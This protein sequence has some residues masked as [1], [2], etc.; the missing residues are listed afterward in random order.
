MAQAEPSENDF[1]PF[2]PGGVM[3]GAGFMLLRTRDEFLREL[4]NCDEFQA[5]CKERGTLPE[6]PFG[7][8]R[9]ID[10]AGRIWTDWSATEYPWSEL[11]REREVHQLA[12]RF[13]EVSRQT[14]LKVAAYAG[15]TG[16]HRLLLDPSDEHTAAW[17]ELQAALQKVQA[18]AAAAKPA[19][20]S[21]AAADR[22]EF[23]KPMRENGVRWKVIA[24]Q[25]RK[26]TG[27]PVDD[28]AFEI[29]CGR[30]RKA[31]QQR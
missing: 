27:D 22:W 9:L 23:A 17:L 21:G 25:W 29:D 10:S 26:E 28:K 4:R 15:M 13:Y 18:S 16:C 31:E 7:Y 20:S 5:A 12:I 6:D 14:I 19:S 1:N 11:P 3:A 24:D 30:A 2:H 8:L